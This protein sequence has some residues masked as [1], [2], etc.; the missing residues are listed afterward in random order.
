MNND[1]KALLQ[2]ITD[3]SHELGTTDYVRGGGGNTSV[4]DDTT[5]WVKPS[6]TTLGGLTPEALVA[7]DRARLAR[8]YGIT[9]PKNAAAREA[10]VQKIMTEAKLP[11]VEGRPSVEAPLHESLSARFVVHTHPALVNGMTCG[12]DG[13]T[14]CARLFPEALWLDYIDPGYTLCMQVR[15]EILRFKQDKGYEPRPIFLKNH[16]VFVAADTEDGICDL[17]ANMFTTLKRHYAQAHV[18]LELKIAPG[19][20]DTEQLQRVAHALGGNMAVCASGL[21]ATSTGPI[22][23]DHLVYAKAYSLIGEPTPQSVADFKKQHGYLPQVIVWDDFVYGAA[24][25]DTRAALALEMA[26]DGA[27]V[28]QLAEAFGGIEFMTDRARLFIEN[29]EVESYRSKQL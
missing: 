2:A 27:L 7:L 1:T 23:P 28:Q 19:E 12:K 21:F 11:G 25:S 6:G 15:D 29:W 8:L 4:K 20:A 26:Q 22:S 14:A 17:Y 9:P 18:S 13:K 5:V 24:S 3:L 10:L 16:G